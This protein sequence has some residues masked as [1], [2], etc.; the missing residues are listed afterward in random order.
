[1][2]VDGYMLDVADTPDNVKE[3]GRLDDGPKASAFPQVRVVDV[4]ECGT[5]AAIAAAFGP[6]KDDERALLARLLDALART[7]RSSP[8]RNSIA[9]NPWTKP[10]PL[11][12][13]YLSRSPA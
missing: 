1:M 8:A 3:F 10:P 11:G 13:T 12:P 5:H 9:F 4:V 2:A 6:C 7:S